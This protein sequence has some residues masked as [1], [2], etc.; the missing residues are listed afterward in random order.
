M[1]ISS[2]I[3]AL[4]AQIRMHYRAHRRLA[5]GPKGAEKNMN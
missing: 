3:S 1:S 2:A 5:A 4:M